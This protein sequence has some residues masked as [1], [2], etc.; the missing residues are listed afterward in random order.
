M[1]WK[2]VH[3]WVEEATL[4]SQL[5]INAWAILTGIAV[6]LTGWTRHKFTPGTVLMLAGPCLILVAWCFGCGFSWWLLVEGLAEQHIGPL[7]IALQA[8]IFIVP[9]VFM[10]WYMIREIRQK[11]HQAEG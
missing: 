3:H 2:I 10:F 4:W 11:I 6:L 7:P 1:D 5:F 8:M 9:T